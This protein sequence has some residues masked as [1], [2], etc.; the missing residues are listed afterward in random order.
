MARGPEAARQSAGDG[1][2]AAARLR[3]SRKWTSLRGET[4]RS[5]F[6]QP[7]AAAAIALAAED[8]RCRIGQQADV[9]GVFRDQ[10]LLQH[11]ATVGKHVDQ[12]GKGV[13]PMGIEAYR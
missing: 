6:A 4:A 5:A 12:G 2:Q 8:F 7:Q 13:D 11:I 10:D 9:G 1:G 3:R